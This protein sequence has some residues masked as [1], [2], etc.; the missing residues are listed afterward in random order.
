MITF[1]LVPDISQATKEEVSALSNGGEPLR[2][3]CRKEIESFSAYLMEY[4]GD[5]AEGLARFEQFAIEGY[6]YQKLRGH[7]D[8]AKTS[9]N[10]PLDGRP[11]GT[12]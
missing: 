7:L 6:L 1:T 2:V 12:P 11:N 9:D 8:D 10:A 4:G 3:L 5:Y